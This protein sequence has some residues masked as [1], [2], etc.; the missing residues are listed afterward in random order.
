VPVAP[1]GRVELWGGWSLSLPND[2][3]VERNPDGSWSAW[4]EA[5]AID[6]SIIE[7]SGSRTGDP[8][9]ATD[10]LGEPASAEGDGWIGVVGTLAEQDEN[11]PVHRLTIAAASTN[12]LA[13]CWIAYRDAAGASWARAVQDSL[14]HRG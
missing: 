9:S 11:G 10:M 3:M 14:R 6:V 1:R 5:H 12:T 7:V 13:S 2:C 8:L 4:D